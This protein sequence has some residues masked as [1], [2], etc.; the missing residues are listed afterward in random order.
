MKCAL[1]SGDWEVMN[2]TIAIRY[3]VGLIFLMGL[4]DSPIERHLYVISIHQP[5][6]IRRLTE[7]GYSYTVVF[8]E[9]CSL[10]IFTY[11][12]VKDPPVCIVNRVHYTDSS[13]YGVTLEHLSY[14]AEPPSN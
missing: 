4:K 5:G 7:P 12:S 9:D 6:E 14:M 10:A 11:S 8:N 2:A 3:S 1:T 13:I